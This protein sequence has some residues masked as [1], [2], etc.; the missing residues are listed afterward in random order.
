MDKKCFLLASLTLPHRYIY[1][2]ML[3][4]LDLVVLFEE[5]FLG[6]FASNWLQ[7]HIAEREFLPIV[8]SLEI[9]CHQFH[10]STVVLHCDN[11]TV[12]YVINKTTFKDSNLM[13]LMGCLM[14]L[15]L[16]HNIHF[17]AKHVSG[18]NNS[19]AD[20]LSRLHGTEIQARFLKWNKN[21]LKYL[22]SWCDFEG[23]TRLFGLQFPFSVYFVSFQ[24]SF[25]YI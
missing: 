3:V 1:S 9:G 11:N 8:R 16:Q 12:V 5:I 20:M 7:F 18:V 15:S 19:A 21:P 22:W 14:L 13:I 17:V 4:I 2:L 23:C 10:N 6:Q 25:F 24:V